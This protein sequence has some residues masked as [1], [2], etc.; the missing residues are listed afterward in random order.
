MALIPIQ[1]VIADNFPV[2]PDW[3]FT[4]A[5]GLIEAGTCV[6]LDGAG[7]IRLVAT[8]GNRA[9]GLAGDNLTN[10]GGGTP[11]AANLTIGAGG[12][13][14]TSTQNR[15]SDFFDETVASSLLTV[16][17]GGG[18]FATDQFAAG[19]AFALGEELYSTAAGLLTNA[20]AGNNV[21][22]GS[23]VAAPSAYPSGVP[24]TDVS[25]SITLG[26]YLD[27]ILIH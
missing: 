13:R 12:N 7:F 16:Y 17:H 23:V 14:Q 2:D 4:G 11:Y 18:R 15:V 20:A 6:D 3:D 25:G 24:G 5:N 19:I 8:A 22:V 1:H 21:V 26:D 27:M 10:A 9:L